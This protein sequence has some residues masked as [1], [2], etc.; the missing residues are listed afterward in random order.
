MAP[1]QRSLAED[2]LGKTYDFAMVRALLPF[3]RPYGASLFA[4]VFLVVVITFIN[5]A[6][7]YV[8]KTAIDRYIVPQENVTGPGHSEGTT[9]DE[10]DLTFSLEDP[11]AA[12]VI[13]RFPGFF[14]VEGQTAR[15]P[16]KDAGHLPPEDLLRLRKGDLRGVTV[17]TALLL[18]LVLAGFLLNFVQVLIME[19]AGQRIMHDLRMRVFTH[20]QVMN[21]PFF[22]RHPVGRLVTRVTNDIQNMNEF[23]TSIIVFVF[24]DLFLFLG[25]TAVL[26]YMNWK[27]TL[28]VLTVAPPLILTAVFFSTRARNIFR[29][30]RVRTAEINTR[31]SETI[32]G[33][34]V[35][36]LFNEEKR[37]EKDFRDLNHRF[38]EAG[39][40]Q[41]HLFALFM[42]IIDIF[43]S[44]TLAMVIYFGGGKVVQ[45]T[46]SLGS[47]VAFIS[48]LRM[49]YMP[50]RDLAEKYNILQDALSSAERI[51]MILNNQ[52]VEAVDGERDEAEMPER[53]TDIRARRL[54]FSYVPDEPVLEEVSF[55]VGE[56]ETVA[57][58]GPTGSGKTTV[59]NL[60]TRFHDPLSGEIFVNGKEIRTWDLSLLRSRMALVPQD[61]YLF[62]GTIYENIIQ[63]NGHLPAKKLDAILEASNLKPLIAR[64]PEGIHKSLTEG[65]GS[66]SS[67]ERQLISIA[68][69]FAR[70]PDVIILDEATSYIDSESERKIQEA[71]ANLMKG[72]T[73][74]I[75]AHRLSTARKADRIFVLQKHRIIEEGTHEELMRG[76]GFYY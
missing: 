30:L 61:P 59:I 16:L 55:H 54:T 10:R 29:E 12:D 52:N 41:I 57:F 2:T 71:L 64:L 23:F 14:E 24:K 4:A 6:L 20:V 68:R 25:I 46:I 21:I 76:K 33:I 75:V 73:S 31:L 62:S 42:P 18:G 60:L 51:F 72:R 53:I 40:R 5:L 8:T 45:N 22:N 19:Y 3:I 15:I 35:I 39:V 56:G 17:M 11:D 63:G 58:V 50:V 74:I 48:Y 13:T 28:I 67:G 34:R 9:R 66:L 32:Q 37:N 65:G 69:A 1:E 38:Y 49:F 70:D 27:L 43:G 36:R 26:L 44:A 7:P 47:L